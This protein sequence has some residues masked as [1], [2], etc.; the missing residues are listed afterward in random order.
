MKEP[1]L[2]VFLDT[3]KRLIEQ[4]EKLLKTLEQVI[5]APY[6]SLCKNKIPALT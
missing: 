5:R 3:Q 6:L 1:T 2:Q 4:G